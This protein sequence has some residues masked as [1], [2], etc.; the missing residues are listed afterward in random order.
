MIRETAGRSL[1]HSQVSAGGRSRRLKK[2]DSKG[3]E[4]IPW[5]R[6]GKSDGESKLLE[7][8]CEPTFVAL[9]SCPIDDRGFITTLF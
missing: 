4:R 8:T 7:Q 9:S 5:T 1:N 2:G 6:P 3:L